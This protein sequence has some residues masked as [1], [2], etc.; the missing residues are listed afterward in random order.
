[1]VDP[2]DIEE[3][4]I[5]KYI[6]KTSPSTWLGIVMRQVLTN[7]TAFRRTMRL[8]LTLAIRNRA[9]RFHHIAYLLEAV[10]LKQITSEVGITH[11]HA[12]F[13]TN[14]TTVALLCR[15]LGG[16]TYSFTVHG[17]DELPIL[18]DNGIV[19][20]CENAAAVIA[21]TEYCR[22]AVL[23]AT[24][25]QFANKVHVVRCGVRVEDFERED[26]AG[27]AQFPQELIC[28]GRLCWQKAQ[29]DIVLAMSIIRDE[30]PSARVHLIGD[31]DQRS[32]I[33]RLIAEHEL[34]DQ[35]IL[36][37]WG[38]NAQVRE[39]LLKTRALVLPSL[40]EGLP[41]VIMEALAMQRPV[42]TTQIAGI[43][44]LVDSSCGWLIAP[45]EVDQLVEA[46]RQCF[47]LP[48]SQ[49]ATLGAQGRA[50]VE[51]LHDVDKNA[52]ELMRCIHPEGA[53]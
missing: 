20:K 26:E 15:M 3:G 48:A 28:V 2:A 42:I 7:G 5:T 49:I 23:A 25:G 27:A 30:F 24:D 4:S 44:E 32:T 9:K 36:H 39:L 51:A 46:M 45:G 37:G 52:V 33:E 53:R 29:T 6:L 40:A 38:T 8:A 50:R 17:P 13:S 11:I 16:P 1:M 21:I 41:I 22:S 18:R 14:S 43:P 35:V 19:P 34:G 47:S 10:R 12:H 31:G